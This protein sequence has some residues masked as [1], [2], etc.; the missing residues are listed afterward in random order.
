[1]QNLSRV[2][3]CRHTKRIRNGKLRVRPF[4]RLQLLRNESAQDTIPACPSTQP[5]PNGNPRLALLLRLN[6]RQKQTQLA[7]TMRES[8]ESRSTRKYMHAIRDT[9]HPHQFSPGQRRVPPECRRR[10]RP[11]N[12]TEKES[13]CP[14]LINLG[15]QPKQTM[16]V[17]A[18][19]KLK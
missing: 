17:A 19:D 6:T 9:G 3:S 12:S 16:L 18:A 1:M 15:S 2:T 11:S 5:P 13:R 10:S 4:L 8:E 7:Q 14:A